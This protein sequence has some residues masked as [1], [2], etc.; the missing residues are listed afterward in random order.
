MKTQKKQLPN[1][2]TF[3]C[4][5]HSKEQLEKLGVRLSIWFMDANG[6]VYSA[7]DNNVIA[8]TDMGF[9]LINLA[10]Y[11]DQEQ[12]IITITDNGEFFRVS[13]NPSPLLTF[14]TDGNRIPI[15]PKWQE[16]TRGGYEYHIYEEFEGKIWGRVYNRSYNWD[17]IRWYKDGKSI[18]YVDAMDLLPINNELTTLQKELEEVRLK[19]KEILEKIEELKTK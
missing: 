5:Q 8:P 1:E 12:P 17:Y 11:L 18:D 6:M 3:V 14:K 2:F 10:D 19:E 16:K 4:D 15:E 13:N 9:P 7:K